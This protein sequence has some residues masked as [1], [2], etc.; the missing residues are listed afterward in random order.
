MSKGEATRQAI[1]GQALDL[2]SEVG[3]EGLTLGVLAQRVQMSKSGLYAH[4][5]SKEVLQRDVLDTAAARFVDVVIAPALKRPRGLPRIELLFEGWL[6]WGTEELTG[7]CPF[8]A[9]AADFDDRPGMVR[10]RLIGHLK[11]MLGT[12]SRS[13]RIAVEEGHFRADLDTDQFAYE[14]WGLLVAYQHYR[15]LLGDPASIRRAHIAFR[16]L[17][18]HS[19]R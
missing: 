8:V 7:G 4:F 11:D 5:A 13:A 15:R 12:V 17:I 6:R 1:L 10:D 14:M 16:G 9:A 19:T 2:T 3:L 18:D